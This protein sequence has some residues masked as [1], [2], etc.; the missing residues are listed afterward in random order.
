MLLR[1]RIGRRGS[2]LFALVDLERACRAL[3][4]GLIFW[5]FGSHAVRKSCIARRLVEIPWTY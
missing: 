3:I 2:R 4:V 1:G 5:A